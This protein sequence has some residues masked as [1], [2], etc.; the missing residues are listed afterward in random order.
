MEINSGAIRVD[1]TVTLSSNGLIYILGGYFKANETALIYI[2]EFSRIYTYDT[3]SLAWGN[4]VAN[5]Q[6]PSNRGLHTTTPSNS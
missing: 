6:I 4:I 3:R 5:G 1:H 2:S